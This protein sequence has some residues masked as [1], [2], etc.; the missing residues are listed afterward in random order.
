MTRV[1]RRLAVRAVATLLSLP[2][3]PLALAQQAAAPPAVT[4]VKVEQRR[5]RRRSPSPAGSRPWTRSICAPG[6][7]ASSRSGCSRK[8]QDVKAGDLLFVIEKAPYQAEIDEVDAA[9]ARAQATLTWP[10]S[11]SGG[12]PS[13]S[14]SRRQPRRELDDATAKAGEARGDLLRAAGER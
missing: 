7:R 10:S 14:R 5:S 6:S 4:V 2:A 11:S 3:A 1:L 8:A 13:W 9:I 12:R